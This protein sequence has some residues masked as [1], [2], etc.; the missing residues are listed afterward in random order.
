MC[1]HA[2]AGTTLELLA[3]SMMAELTQGTIVPVASEPQPWLDW[4]LN[5]LPFSSP[6]GTV[7]SG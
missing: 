1:E 3:L 2:E 5:G 7:S 4:W 6:E